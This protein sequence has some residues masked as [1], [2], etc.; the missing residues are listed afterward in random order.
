MF[1]VTQFAEYWIS[2]H[3]EVYGRVF[4]TFTKQRVSV[5]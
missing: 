3:M 2:F 4:V 1:V 5:S